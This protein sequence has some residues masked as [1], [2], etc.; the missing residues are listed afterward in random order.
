MARQGARV[1]RVFISSPG[2]VAE[3]RVLAHRVLKDELPNDPFVR[4]RVA[5]DIVSWD[6]PNAPVPL[7]ANV[8][9][10]DAISRGLPRPS[11]C[12]LVIV[13]LW[14][15]MGT[16]L[17]SDYRKSSGDNYLSGTEWEFEDAL[18][19]SRTPKPDILI[20]RR[21]E[22]V[23]FDA[24]DPELNAKIAQYNLVKD[25]FDH[26]R[27][28]DGSLRSGY[29]DYKDS[30]HFADIFRSHVKVWIKSKVH[31]SNRPPDVLTERRDSSSTPRLQNAT[32]NLLYSGII[33]TGTFG[34][35]IVG[36]RELAAIYR[37]NQRYKH[38]IIRSLESAASRPS[39]ERERIHALVLETVD[40][41]SIRA[42]ILTQRRTYELVVGR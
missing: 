11:E 2:D 35:A 34:F 38:E 13:I 23:K 42:Y 31:E 20:Y 39:E 19:S 17:P 7:W 1:L 40:D 8:T 26:L 6:D 22:K 27:N 32:R 16:P 37:E 29:H 33:L 18:A 5:I 21:S 4:G 3:E 36:A 14:S 24:D 25:L 28:P 9:P 10:Q 15:R 12:D 41:E 30:S